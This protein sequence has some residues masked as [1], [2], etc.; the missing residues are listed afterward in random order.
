MLYL[1]FTF[2]EFYPVGGWHDL[3]SSYSTFEEAMRHQVKRDYGQIVRV[4]EG[5]SVLA[6]TFDSGKDDAWRIIVPETCEDRSYTCCEERI[7]QPPECIVR[8]EK[9]RGDYD[10]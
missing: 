8:Q 9:E 7:P 10:D 4:V 5:E 2:N 6:A 1:V 3:A